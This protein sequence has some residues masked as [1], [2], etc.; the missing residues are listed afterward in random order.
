[1]VL[2][3]LLEEQGRGVRYDMLLINCGLHDIKT[4]PSTGE[5]QVPLDQYRYNLERIAAVGKQMARSVIWIR[6]T[7]AVEAI[8]NGKMAAFYRYHDDVLAYNE[9]A[10]EIMTKHGIP[11]LDLYAFTRGFGEAAYRDH[12]HFTDEVCQLQAAYIAGYLERFVQEM[13]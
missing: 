13:G 10:D 3:Y 12:V 6:T 9:A 7:D 2:E 8:H 4:G 5:K 11:I 1:M